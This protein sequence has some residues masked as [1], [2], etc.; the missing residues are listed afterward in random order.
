MKKKSGFTLVEMLAVIVVLAIITTI[1]VTSAYSLVKD[2]K[3][4]Q[5]NVLMKEIEQAA[6]IYLNDNYESNIVGRESKYLSVRLLIDNGCASTYV[7]ISDLVEKGLLKKS[8][9]NDP[10]DNS[11]LYDK[12]VR[13]YYDNS[14]L[15]IDNEVKDSAGEIC[16]NYNDGYYKI[17]DQTKTFLRYNNQIWRIL[18]IN[19]DGSVRIILNDSIG[20][21]VFGKD[22]TYQSSYVLANMQYWYLYD[23]SSLSKN[24]IRSASLNLL[25]EAEYLTVKNIVG[26]DEF[27]I[28]DKT[29]STKGKTTNGVVG[30]NTYSAAIKPVVEILPTAIY[31]SGTGTSD[32]PYTIR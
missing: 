22:S 23:I 5:Y 29:D 21:S 12:Y 24:L 15:V 13:M 6:K 16:S 32:N 28:L 31:V 20:S 14:S 10:R 2:N 26:T 3:N 1:V 11:S 25:S 9:I 8:D 18:A 7:K 27:W 4:D 17:A 30:N 19:M